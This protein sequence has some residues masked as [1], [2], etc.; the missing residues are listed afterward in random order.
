M[1]AATRTPMTCPECG[2]TGVDDSPRPVVFVIQTDK[3]GTKVDSPC[4]MCF[5]RGAIWAV[6]E[7]SAR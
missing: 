6:D 1:T 7:E 3:S 5:G 4:A 2:G